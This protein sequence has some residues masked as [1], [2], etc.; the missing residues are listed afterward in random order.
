M[1]SQAEVEAAALPQRPSEVKEGLIA[2]PTVRASI[3][4]PH[5]HALHTHPCNPHNDPSLQM[6]SQ[7]CWLPPQPFPHPLYLIT[8]FF[9]RSCPPPTAHPPPQTSPKVGSCLSPPHVP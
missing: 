4:S 8:G 9:P 1:S 6:R 3:G 2:S 5:P 7:G